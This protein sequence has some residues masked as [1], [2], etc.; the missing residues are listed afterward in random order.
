MQTRGRPVYQDNGLNIL[1]KDVEP[2]KRGRESKKESK[3]ER[4]YFPSSLM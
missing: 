2:I 4:T 1:L 3:R